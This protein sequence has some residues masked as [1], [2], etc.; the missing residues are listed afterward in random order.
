MG[1]GYVGAAICKI[2]M[3]EQVILSNTMCKETRDTMY[4]DKVSEFMYFSV[5]CSLVMRKPLIETKLFHVLFMVGTFLEC[6]YML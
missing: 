1:L 3:T 4:S 6:Y 5:Q 2:H